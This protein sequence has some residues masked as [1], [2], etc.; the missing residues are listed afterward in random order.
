[1]QISHQFL[2]EVLCYSQSTG[3]FTYKIQR[4]QSSPGDRA[5]YLH[6]SGYRHVGFCG[7][8]YKEHRLAWF[9]IYGV[10][11]RGDLDHINGISDDNRVCNLR[12]VNDSLNSLNK[13]WGATQNKAQFRGVSKHQTE[14][15]K[16]KWRVRVTVG[17]K[18]IPIGNFHSL[19][20]AIAARVAAENKYYGEYAPS[21][22]C[23]ERELCLAG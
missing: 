4:G 17:G 3:V 6:C 23:M 16:P 2:T 21:R 11:P 1:M 7:K 13:H 15:G 5:G 12:E 8:Q 19:D 22:G 14:R 10:W 9:Y 18:R 20:D